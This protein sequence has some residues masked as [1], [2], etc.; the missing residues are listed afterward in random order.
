LREQQKTKVIIII[1]IIII[2]LKSDG[3]GPAVLPLPVTTLWVV[4]LGHDQAESYMMWSQWSVARQGEFLKKKK[5]GEC[6][7]GI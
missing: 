5:K 7:S 2:V 6:W 1:I 4:G 3:Q